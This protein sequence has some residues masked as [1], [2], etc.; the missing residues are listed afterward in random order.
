MS[1][2]TSKLENHRESVM[3]S[4]LSTTRPTS[5]VKSYVEVTPKKQIE[6][7]RKQNSMYMN[8]HAHKDMLTKWIKRNSIIEVIPSKRGGGGGGSS[9]SGVYGSKKYAESVEMTATVTNQ[10]QTQ[11]SFTERTQSVSQENEFL[12][13]SIYADVNDNF[14]SSQMGKYLIIEWNRFYQIRNSLFLIII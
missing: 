12:Q 9:S 10:T 4:S 5:S 3:A 11:R 2:A 6:N 14:P 1:R 7:L 13:T 8:G